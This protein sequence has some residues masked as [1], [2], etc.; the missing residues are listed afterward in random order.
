MPQLLILI[1]CVLLIQ[2]RLRRPT[3]PPL[4]QR[5]L[6]DLRP[7][8]PGAQS[9]WIFATLAVVCMS[10]AGMT[11]D[12]ENNRDSVAPWFTGPLADNAQSALYALY[13]VLAYLWPS[14]IR[15][16]YYV[17]PVKPWRYLSP[18]DWALA[19]GTG[20][21]AY[22][23]LRGIESVS[24]QVGITVGIFVL[25]LPGLVSLFQNRPSSQNIV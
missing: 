25:V 5:Q 4:I 11:L 17:S 23:G 19:L 1:L 6:P 3:K 21:A 8:T 24:N 22:F 20:L 12:I 15:T 18:Q 10:F 13:A 9:L 14:L 7:L 16:L 2:D